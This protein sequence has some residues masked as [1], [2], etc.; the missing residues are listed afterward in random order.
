MTSSG[1]KYR[2]KLIAVPIADTMKMI[3]RVIATLIVAH[4]AG[5]AAGDAPATGFA[6]DPLPAAARTHFLKKELS[7]HPFPTK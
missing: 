2:R 4:S 3:F 1:S 6:L 5:G 7:P